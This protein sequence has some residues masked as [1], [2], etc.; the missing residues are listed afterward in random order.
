MLT[1]IKKGFLKNVIF[2][3][4]ILWNFFRKTASPSQWPKGIQFHFLWFLSFSFPQFKDLFILPFSSYLWLTNSIYFRSFF[5]NLIH[6]FSSVLGKF[7][8]LLYCQN[9]K[10]ICIVLVEMFFAESNPYNGF[11]THPSTHPPIHPG[12]DFFVAIFLECK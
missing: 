5:C 10:S 4:L 11:Y 6:F 8:L 7:I 3:Q 9:S 2:I 12:L 1:A